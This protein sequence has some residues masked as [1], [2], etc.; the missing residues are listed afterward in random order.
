L[1]SFDYINFDQEFLNDVVTSDSFQKPGN[2]GGPQLKPCKRP[3]RAAL[4]SSSDTVELTA[5]APCIESEEISDEPGSSLKDKGNDKDVV[6]KQVC[7]DFLVCNEN[8]QIK[9]MQSSREKV[10]KQQNTV[11]SF[12][13]HFTVP[14]QSAMT[15]F[16]SLKYDPKIC[17]S[18]QLELSSSRMITMPSVHRPDSSRLPCLEHLDN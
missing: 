1:L 12:E 13:S 6:L 3:I 17:L 5:S 9:H 14:S 8:D 11:L 16:H 4:A 18:G 15:G 7:P 2:R 10:V